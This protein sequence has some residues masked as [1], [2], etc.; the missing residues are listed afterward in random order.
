[1]KW[2][3]TDVEQCQLLQAQGHP[4]LFAALEAAKAK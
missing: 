4:A 3:I 2:A 1:M